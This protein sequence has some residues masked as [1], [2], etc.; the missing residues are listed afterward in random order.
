MWLMLQQPKGDDYVLATGRTTAVRQFAEWAFEAVGINLEWDGAG[1]HEKARD[2]RTGRVVIEVDP[3][4]FRLTEADLLL[5]DPTKAR[6]R[7]GWTHETSVRELAVEMVREDIKSMQP[8]R[9][10]SEA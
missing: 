2:G 7:L 4:Y 6:E 5:G 9:T 10:M 1:V 8:A 3:R